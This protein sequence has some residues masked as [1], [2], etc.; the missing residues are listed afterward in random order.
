MKLVPIV[1]AGSLAANVV[2]LAFFLSDKPGQAPVPPTPREPATTALNPQAPAASPPALPQVSLD[3][4]D[5]TT[6]ASR[7]RAAGYSPNLIRAVVTAVVEE[8]FSARRKAALLAQ[9]DQPYW[10]DRPLGIMD[11]KTMVAL[12]ELRAEQTKLLR[13]L[14]PAEIPAVDEVTLASLRLRFGPLT[15]EH[16]EQVQ[17][18]VSDYSVLKL[19]VRAEAK[20]AIFRP[21]DRDQ[22]AL[23]EREER[24]DLAKILSPAETEAYELRSSATADVLRSSLSAFKPTEAEFRA[25]FK[26]TR[27]AEEK[28]GSFKD[29]GNRRQVGG[30]VLARAK[31]LLSPERFK[32][33][34]DTTPFGP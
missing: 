34:R 13:A 7:L 10:R 15:A 31:T 3:S 12:A 30:V 11:P 29:S 20:D 18:V 16:Y 33:F 23:L 26:I 14:L 1:F 9:A 27:D 2:L 28:F 21:E 25:L 6:L 17:A 22:L 32:Q 4:G 5:L 8:Q 24:A 19:K